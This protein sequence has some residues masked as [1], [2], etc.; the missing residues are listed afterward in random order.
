LNGGNGTSQHSAH[1]IFTAIGGNVITV[2]ARLIYNILQ[3]P[4]IALK[5]TNNILL[6]VLSSKSGK[7]VDALCDLIKTHFANNIILVEKLNASKPSDFDFKLGPNKPFIPDSRA[8]TQ[9]LRQDEKAELE[10]YREREHED[11]PKVDMSTK[12]LITEAQFVLSRIKSSLDF[13]QGIALYKDID[14]RISSRKGSH[15]QKEN[16]NPS[17]FSKVS[18][19]RETQTL[20]KIP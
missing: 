15:L 9:P 14:D 2:F 18:I 8:T 4:S 20:H 1:I 3:Y 12:K 5:P 17:I 11:E 7:S 13:R 10:T 6:Q 16:R 19:I